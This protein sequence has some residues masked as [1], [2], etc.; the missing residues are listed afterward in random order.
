MK[1]NRLGIV[2]LANEEEATNRLLFIRQPNNS[3]TVL[4]HIYSRILESLV[5]RVDGTTYTQL[6][7]LLANSFASIL[8]QEDSLSQKEQTILQA[9]SE[10]DLDRL[11]AEGTAKKRDYWKTI[12]SRVS[13]WW[14]ETHSAAGYSLP[15]LKGI[16]KYCS[17]SAP[18]Y[19][20]RVTR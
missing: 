4:F 7:Y 12:E 8:R 6:D 10:R 20:E 13:Q 9:L 17:Y 16:V 3:E 11:G 19:R 2:G 5:E 18:H 15:I 1:Q 14:L